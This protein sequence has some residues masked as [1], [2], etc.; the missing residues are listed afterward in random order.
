[1]KYRRLA[2]LDVSVLALGAANF[3]GVGS[4]RKLVGKGDT[5][6]EAHALLDCAVALG[7]NLIDTA[8]TYGAGA[9]EDIIGS[10]L[11]SRGA[12]VRDKV[13][14]SSKVGIH[15]GLGRANVLR[16]IERTLARLRVDRID[17]YLAHLPD[18]ATAWEDVLATMRD[19]VRAGKIRAFGISNVSANDVKACARAGSDGGQRF[20][21]MQNMFNLLDRDDAHNGVIDAC[22]SCGM[23]YTSYSPLAGGL[24]SGKY[25]VAGAIPEGTRLALRPDMYGHAWTAANAARIEA[26]K[27]AAAA[28]AMSPAGLATWWVVNCEF[29]TSVMVGPRR[30]EQLQRMVREAVELPDDRELWQSLA[31]LDTAAHGTFGLHTAKL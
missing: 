12:A 8:G 24:L 16:E 22:R 6:A 14:I 25:V 13:L 9:S 11:A 17:L 19:L 20:E 3:G 5:E 30:P 2:G 29:V 28:R 10:W 1:M 26:L 23:K 18:P 7:I 4:S 15:G 27:A 31:R 21:W